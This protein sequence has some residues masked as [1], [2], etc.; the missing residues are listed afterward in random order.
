MAVQPQTPYKEYTANGSAKSFALE[1]DC[2]NQDHLIV[3]VDEV[4]P[5]V[6]T[7]S[8]SGGA[9]V[10]STAPTNGKKIT[11]QRNTPA[12][13][14]T[15]YKSTDNSF[16]PD[17]INK[18]FDRIWL[19]LQEL[20]LADWLLRLYVDKKNAEL[21]QN[22][23]NLKGYV[24]LKD[25]ELRAY[26][27]EEI[28]KQGVALDQLDEYYNYLMQRLAQVAVEK[29]WD[30]TFVNYSLLKNKITRTIY[31][32]LYETWSIKDF[33]AIGDGTLHTLQEWVTQGK[34]SNLTAIQF[35]FPFVTSLTESIDRVAIQAAIKALPLNTANVGILTPKGFANGG[36]IFLPRGRY[37]IDKKITMQRGLRLC[38]ESR[39]SSQLISFISND[40]VLQYADQGRYLQDEIVVR[41]LSIWQDPSV[42]ATAGAAIDVIEGPIPVISLYINVD[43]VIIEGTYIGIRHMAGVGGGI[44]NSNITKCVSHGVH[45]TGTI[46]TTSMLFENTYS[47]QN[48]GYGYVVERGAYMAWVACASDSNG[49]GGYHINQTKGYSLVGSG[50]ESNQGP[51]VKLSSA[52]GGVIDIFAIANLGG[53][54][55][56][57][58]NPSGAIYAPSGDW[59]GDGFAVRGPGNTPVYLGRGL[60]LRGEYN[61][62]RVNYIASVLDEAQGVEGRLVGGANNRWS[63]GSIQQPDPVSG[64]SVGGN[65]GINTTV[66]FKSVQQHGTPGEFRNVATYTQFITQPGST[67]YK[68]GIG[69]FIPNASK[70]AGST[71]LHTIGECIVEQTQGT[72]SNINLKIDTL[73]GGD[74]TGDWN[75]Y[76]DSIRRSYLKGSLQ[77]GAG[78]GVHG[79][80]PPLAKRSITGKKTPATIAE[81]NAVL[82]NL[83]SALVAYGFVTDDRI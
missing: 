54:I 40:S 43:N 16:R 50:A 18:D 42:V 72:N 58:S 69:H 67:T 55:D 73:A 14:S 4:E 35:V 59:E 70:G 57:G 3:L 27:M 30:A 51:A 52:G 32:K 39:E 20:G 64:F 65:A 19:K 17:P 24:D 53:A 23:N 76:S 77:L 10:F 44:R 79:N 82:D 34:F 2:D 15:T 36:C 83:V 6:G 25:D 21:Q 45:I 68:V 81:Q 33:G 46:S 78:L 74:P 1:F 5:V 38:G 13:R 80:T 7:W 12:A 29:G 62:K 71:I 66:G 49:L 61:T 26:L 60:V 8:L 31:E 37:V 63:I 9:V 28:R 48:G 47:H 56:A 75:I 41:D 22:I 11:I